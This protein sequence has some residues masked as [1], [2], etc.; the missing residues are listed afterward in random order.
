MST[1]WNLSVREDIYLTGLLACYLVFEERIG[2]ACDIMSDS[3]EYK[4]VRKSI[5]VSR[6]RVWRWRCRYIGVLGSIG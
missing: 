5:Q 2:R 6:R 3:G 4:S 1:S